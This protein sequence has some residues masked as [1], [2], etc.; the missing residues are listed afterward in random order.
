MFV[1][2]CVFKN[3]TRVFPAWFVEERRANDML[4]TQPNRTVRFPCQHFKDYR[5][6]TTRRT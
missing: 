3:P 4:L 1:N 2:E 5:A 6:S